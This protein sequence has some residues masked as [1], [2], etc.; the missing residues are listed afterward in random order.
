[1]ETIDSWNMPAANSTFAIGGFSDFLETFMLVESSGISSN[2]G[3]E[4]PP[5]LQAAN[6]WSGNPFG[7]P[8]PTQGRLES[9]CRAK[10]RRNFANKRL[11]KILLR[12]TSQSRRP[13]SSNFIQLLCKQQL[14]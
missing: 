12:K 13:V 11:N 3:A 4:K 6:R 5:L 2:F 14:N 10:S 8:A 7:T 1:L 9:F